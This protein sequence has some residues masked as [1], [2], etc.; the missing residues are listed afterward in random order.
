MLQSRIA[1]GEGQNVSPELNQ[2]LLVLILKT[3]R[4]QGDDLERGEWKAE[5]EIEERRGHILELTDRRTKI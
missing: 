4:P 2:N 1:I 3:K 5:L